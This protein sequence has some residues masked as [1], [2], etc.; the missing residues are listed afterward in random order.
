V[1]LGTAGVRWSDLRYATQRVEELG[2]DSLWAPDHLIA[3]EGQGTATRLEAW[4]ALAALA[5]IT[6]RIRLGPLVSPVTFRHPAVLAK[7]AATLDHISGGRVILGLGAGGRAEEHRAYGLPFGTPR[8]R[9]ERL[10]ETAAIVRSLWDE[11]TSN[12]LGRHYQ[13]QGAHAMPKPLQPRL[14]LL[15]AGSGPGPMRVAAKF[16]DFWNAIG[17]PTV[18]AEKVPVLREYMRGYARE[19]TE[20]S[21]SASFRLLIR[22]D[23]AGVSRRLEELDPVWRDDAYRI[24]GGTRPVLDTL[25]AYV[26]A[27]VRAFLVQFPAPFDFLTLE[28]LAGEVREHLIR[29]P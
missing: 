11:P 23:E 4:Q 14:P 9:T 18:F 5:T 20:V 7:M 2:Y 1:Q 16:G 21:I 6:T 10:E 12:F 25:R 3:S 19:P 8:E 29:D 26:R 27:G 24:T 22:D 15:V 28:R 17:L 13:L